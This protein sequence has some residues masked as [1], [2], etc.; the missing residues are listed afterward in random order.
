MIVA[1]SIKSKL[2]LVVAITFAM[3]CAKSRV[4]INVN[5]GYFSS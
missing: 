1:L 2:A 5:T 3:R 4:N